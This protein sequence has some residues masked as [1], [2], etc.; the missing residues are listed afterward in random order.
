M[1]FRQIK[2]RRVMSTQ[3][4]K[5][6]FHHFHEILGSSKEALQQKINEHGGFK[7]AVSDAMH[8]AE[9]GGAIHFEHEVG[10]GLGRTMKDVAEDFEDVK[11][12]AVEAKHSY[13][14]INLHDTSVSGMAKNV[15]SAYSGNF[16][17]AAAYMNTAGAVFRPFR[18]VFRGA[19]EGFGAVG[20]VLGK[21]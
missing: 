9:K 15:T 11:V 18:D 3:I 19:G 14:K 21:L 2:S 13:D 6:K 12:E 16:H 5:A 4:I 8:S 17:S 20:T 7:Q 10:G 1:P